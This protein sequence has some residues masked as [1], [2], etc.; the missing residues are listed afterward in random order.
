MGWFAKFRSTTLNR[1]AFWCVEKGDFQTAA[2]L[3]EKAIQLNPKSADSH[4]ELCICYNRLGKYELAK[5]EAQMAVS[6]DPHNPKF[7]NG[8]IG[9]LVDNAL[10]S[11]SQ[12]E[13]VK[14]LND[15]SL[16]IDQLIDEY[17]EYAPA[18]LGRAT[19]L[20]LRG[21]KEELW[22]REIEKAAKFYKSV[23][24]TGANITATD[25]RIDHIIR[26]CQ[27]RCKDMHQFWQDLPEK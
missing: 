9:A 4:N 11:K 6:C 19:V 7:K 27:I 20:A 18:Y 26:R 16:I 12:R 3:L 23:G 10:T 5:K 1:R 24:R 15:I 22:Q 13:L 21:T 8:L 17:P 14:I 25:E 2:S